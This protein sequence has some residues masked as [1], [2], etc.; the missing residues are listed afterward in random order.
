M[1]GHLLDLSGSSLCVSTYLQRKISGAS[2]SLGPAIVYNLSVIGPTDIRHL[3]QVGPFGLLTAMREF[4]PS[5]DRV[6]DIGQIEQIHPGRAAAHI[7]SSDV[8]TRRKWRAVRKVNHP[9]LEI[10]CV[11][12]VAQGDVEN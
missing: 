3:I 10:V 8:R 7:C 11:E 1:I 4:P 6:D 12:E 2:I 5:Q 9:Q